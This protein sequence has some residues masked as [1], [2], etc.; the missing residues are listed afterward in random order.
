[1]K[2]Y[3]AIYSILL[4][5]AVIGMWAMILA[6]Q[7][8]PEGKLEL[9]FHLYAEFAM[10]VICL[11]SGVMMLKGMKFA[12]MTN[13]GGLGMVTYSTINAAGYYGQKDDKP[14]MTLFIVL[15]ILTIGAI[16]LHYVVRKKNN[17]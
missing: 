15:A 12:R 8:L 2:N 3:I 1:M 5:L 4:G 7:E 13:M 11:V 16:C 9:A 17:S 6:T 10:A 14:M